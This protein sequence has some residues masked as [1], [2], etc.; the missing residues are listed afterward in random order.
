[1]KQTKSVLNGK[2]INLTGD[3][4]IITSNNFNVDK[5]GNMSCS[6]AN[7]TNGN[8]ILGSP[9]SGEGSAVLRVYS[10]DSGPSTEIY[11]DSVEIF[12]ENP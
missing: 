5:D 4:T 12:Q 6:N 1:M 7:I 9:L 8:V 3:N 11:P 10:G 2:N